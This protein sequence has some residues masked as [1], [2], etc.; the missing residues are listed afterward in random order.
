MV[1]PPAIA[2]GTDLFQ[3]ESAIFTATPIVAR[4][5]LRIA[6]FER[7]SVWNATLSTILSA[8]AFNN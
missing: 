8:Q 3:G 6:A 1:D 2:G 4:W 5:M 7:Y